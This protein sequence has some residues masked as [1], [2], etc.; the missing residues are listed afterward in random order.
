MP[1]ELLL[2]LD[3]GST[4]VTALVVEPDGRVL[5]R[6]GLALGARFPGPGRVEQDP[7]AFVE[8]SRDV[9]RA[10]LAEAAAEARDLAALGIATQRATALAW[11]AQSGAP[12]APA[13]GWQDQ[14]PLEIAALL[15]ERGLPLG[16]QPAAAKFAW[17]LERAPE[18][19]AAARAGTLRLGTPDAWLQESLSGEA[20]T[21]PGQASCT[22]LYDPGRDDWSPVL[23][24]RVRVD[25]EILPK[26]VRTAEPAGETRRSLLGAPVPIAA[27]AGDQQASAF[28][29]RLRRPGDAK[30]TLGTAA[31]LDV[32]AGSSFPVPPSGT[33]PIALWRLPGETTQW[34][35]EGHVATA[36]AAVEW[37]V[38]VG[39]LECPADLD[40]LAASVP[41][42]EG[43][44]VVPAF[45]GL[46]TPWANAAARGFIGGLTRGTTRAHLARALIEG[47]AQRCADLCEALLHRPGPLPV[48][49]GLAASR[50]LL[51]A[52]ADTSGRTLV[53]A[54]ERET[55]ALGAAWL[56]AVGQGVGGPLEGF[57]A[58]GEGERVEPALDA[59]QRGALR[60]RWRRVVERSCGNE[61]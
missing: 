9:L 37:L 19:A 18:I 42:A 51:Q 25:P 47:L 12:L 17:W 23:A 61:P 7:M 29:Q 30:L 26:V 55:T 20:V 33:L 13:L 21:D 38:A 16:T 2:A 34:C 35:L 11:D 4:R 48:D 60:G 15:R 10:A 50:L 8:R 28:A 53:G 39:L 41:S 6:A 44:A 54:R 1:G 3:L 56:A 58:V 59:A 57:A 22:G 52:L 27:R 45:Q 32:H 40:R 43:V 49:G 31:M 14:R 46:G 36:G 24:E 5:G